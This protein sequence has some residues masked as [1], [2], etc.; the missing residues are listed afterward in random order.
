M[1][2]EIFNEVKHALHKMLEKIRMM[3]FAERIRI[4]IEPESYK[5]RKASDEKKDRTFGSSKKASGGSKVDVVYN[6]TYY[7]GTEP[8][9]S[10]IIIFFNKNKKYTKKK[11]NKLC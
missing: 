5:V 1:F 3:D 6:I 10:K 9:D 11:I 8:F 2:G 7:F 4:S